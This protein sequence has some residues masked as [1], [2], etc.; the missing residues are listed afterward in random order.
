MIAELGLCC[1]G[2]RVIF[3]CHP[4]TEMWILSTKAKVKE[5]HFLN[6]RSVCIFSI[7]IIN[8]DT[9]PI[10][11]VANDFISKVIWSDIAHK[12]W[13]TPECFTALVKLSCLT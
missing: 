13:Y 10:I 11:E 7:R 12:L 6:V 2:I 9:L 1:C 3:E 5:K 8:V 4:E